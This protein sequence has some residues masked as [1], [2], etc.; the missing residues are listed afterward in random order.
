[1]III[2]AGVL[3]SSCS[4]K[5]KT[6]QFSEGYV[7]V[8]NVNLYYATVGSG[9][10]LVVLHGGPGLSH[11]YLKPQLDSLLSPNFTLLYYDQRGSG[12]SEGV[13][14]TLKL[15]MRTYVSDLEQIRKHFRLSQLN[16]M[17]HSFGGLLAMNYG[18]TYP[19]NLKSMVLIDTDAASYA[20]RTP[21]Q[22]KTINERLSEEQWK[23][24]ESIAA[25]QS[26]KNYDIK[27]YDKYYK[28]FLTSYF[29]NPIDT[30]HLSLG[31]DSISIP[32]M[33][34]TSNYVRK[35]LGKYDI[36]SELVKIK[37]P[38]LILQGTESIFSVAGA[39]AIDKLLLDSKLQLFENCGHFEYIEAPAKFKTSIEEFYG[40]N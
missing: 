8:E 26:Y 2:L 36:H 27:T 3:L 7:P 32:K 25:S 28:T 30:A 11:K 5:P 4:Q 37:C 40:V 38:A 22:I 18:I 19:E 31:F 20:L 15:N 9:D 6:V 12:W 35:D 29:A 17:G 13:E 39:E 24:L 10:T 1:M 16:L 23:Y 21:Y 14:D 34:K 33:S